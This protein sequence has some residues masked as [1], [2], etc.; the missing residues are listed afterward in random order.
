MSSP[1]L[2]WWRKRPTPIRKR[3]HRPELE[4]LETRDVPA[5]FKVISPKDDG[6]VGTLRWA[7]QQANATNS[8][9]DSIVFNI[10]TG[11]T[12]TIT[13]D[14]GSG[15]LPPITDTGL[16]ING[17]T[18]GN[19]NPGV[20]IQVDGSGAGGGAEGLVIDAGGVAVCGLD[21]TNFA[22]AGI[23]IAN[24][25]GSA[26]CVIGANYIGTNLTGTGP[27]ANAE[28]IDVQGP[29]N[30]IGGAMPVKGGRGTDA[31]SGVFPLIS[32]NT[33]NGIECSNNGLRTVILN[34]AIGTNLAGTVA[35]P[36]GA[37]PNGA[38]G[39]LLNTSGNTIGSTAGY[40]IGGNLIS[41]NTG[42]GIRV[43]GSNNLITGNYIGTRVDGLA[44]LP[45]LGDGVFVT[46]TAA[47]NTIG[48]SGTTAVNIISGNTQSG[49]ELNGNDG[50][51]VRL[52]TLLGNWIGLGSDG[53]TAIANVN[54]G[55]LIHGGASQNTVGA[56]N[57][58]S[59]N[60][61]NGVEIADSAST[62]NLVT[63]SYIGTN[64]AGTSAVGNYTGIYISANQNTIGGTQ[65]VSGNVISGNR[66]A[67]IDL[68]GANGGGSSNAIFGNYIGTD[69]NGTA[70][71]TNGYLGIKVENNANR[72]TIGGSAASAGNL[73]SGNGNN[74]GGMQNTGYGI[75]V[76]N[77]QLT[78][79]QG[80][81]IGIAA[82]GNALGNRNS[83]IYLFNA[84]NTMIGGAASGAGNVISANGWSQGQAIG[85]GIEIA[86][87]SN[88]S[89]IIN[90]IV[91]LTSTGDQAAGFPNALGWLSDGG[92]NTQL[93]G[94]QHP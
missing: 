77:A 30:T 65:A 21:I 27:A 23:L 91:G 60:T 55:V 84:L 69:V 61:N 78:V 36:N 7:I 85:W 41:G 71:L 16:F 74:S 62:Q 20:Y 48:G 24:P 89:S 6:T 2:Y 39:I 40:G 8:G 33:G 51:Q 90:N 70:Q 88:N 82:D 4:W 37:N 12:Q 64:S 1:R 32:G 81:W 66:Y 25:Q 26:G 79:I 42:N 56:A 59:G 43:N 31:G 93:N 18:Q 9:S 52:N 83:G 72:N 14:A 5:I 94:N 73:I 13:L 58:I 15:A 29:D 17:Y 50:A 92:Q 45:N 10:V 3:S 47:G 19:G 68:D 57:V 38:N 22:G 87:T 53:A 28:G 67:G 11:I 46:G 35:I 75:F 44:A 86:G 76:D 34:C 80:N 63:G 54:D 49:V